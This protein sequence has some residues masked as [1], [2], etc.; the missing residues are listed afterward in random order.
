MNEEFNLDDQR[1]K[2]QEFLDAMEDAKTDE[3][4]LAEVL[5]QFD[6][7]EQILQEF[8]SVTH[9]FQHL[10]QEFLALKRSNQLRFSPNG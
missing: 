6:F 7:D 5:D 2:K 9:E 1:R 8:N 10:K 4:E 3:H